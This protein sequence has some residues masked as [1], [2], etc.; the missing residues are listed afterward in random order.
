MTDYTDRAAQRGESSTG[1]H[2]EVADRFAIIPEA[3]LYDPAVDDGMIRVYGVLLRHG[4]DPKNCY[5]SHRRIGDL[6]GKSPRTVPAIIARLVDRGWVEVVPRISD[7]GDHDSNGYRVHSRALE[8]GVYAS[9]RGPLP[10]PARGGSTRERAPNESKENESQ[11]NE[12]VRAPARP[13]ARAVSHDMAF[14]AFWSAYPRKVGKP[15][16]RQ[17]WERALRRADGNDV[18]IVEGAHSYAAD[19]N[20]ED[21][22]TAHPTTWLNRDGWAD[23]ALPERNGRGTNPY[24]RRLAT[25][26]AAGP[27]PP[28]SLFALPGGEPA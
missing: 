12:I 24:L 4:S 19:P 21:Q 2:V 6:T 23:P 26:P 11:G 22:Y 15:K 16:A 14:E 5:P 20:R 7:H 10:A 13:A 3:L 27:M 25:R 9:A 28:G 1:P 17:A 18:T 8:R